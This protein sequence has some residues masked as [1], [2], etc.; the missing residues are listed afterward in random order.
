MRTWVVSPEGM[1]GT[2]GAWRGNSLVRSTCCSS[3]GP[4]FLA[5]TAAT[6]R[7]AWWQAHTCN[8]ASVGTWDR[9]FPGAHWPDSLSYLVGSRPV[10]DFFHKKNKLRMATGEQ[11]QGWP[12]VTCAHSPTKT[13]RTKQGFM[14][15]V[16][17]LCMAHITLKN[18]NWP[19]NGLF[20]VFSGIC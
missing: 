17:V 8:S 19:V 2:A 1:W 14:G 15:D 13:R 9:Q 11:H 4:R 16:I 10:R 6:Q 7:W 20:D 5:I 18:A 3:R 12:L